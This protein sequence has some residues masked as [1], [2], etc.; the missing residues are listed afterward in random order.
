[1]ENKMTNVECV[2]I[3]PKINKKQIHSFSCCN[4]TF[5]QI[6]VL[7]HDTSYS[8]CKLS[9]TIQ[10]CFIAMGFSEWSSYG[11]RYLTNNSADNCLINMS[12]S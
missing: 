1:M 5:S 12:K 7:Q 8:G 9:G 10:L 4:K 6:S 3:V 2:A 11:I